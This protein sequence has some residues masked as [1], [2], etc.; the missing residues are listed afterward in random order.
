MKT[1]YT[2]KQ[3]ELYTY[4]QDCTQTVTRESGD[5]YY[6]RKENDMP[7]YQ[8][9]IAQLTQDTGENIDLAYEL[10][11]TASGLLAN[12]ELGDLADTDLYELASDSASVYTWDRLQL[13]DNNNQ[14]EISDIM[15]EYEYE[16]IATACAIWYEQ[17][18]AEVL[19]A[20]VQM[21]TD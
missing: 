16:D 13:L 11:N 19:H 1:Q 3:S 17:K 20:M 5:A 15:K 12:V 10:L 2:Q 9:V 8:N 18:V 4:L 7:G 21:V 14:Q 6:V